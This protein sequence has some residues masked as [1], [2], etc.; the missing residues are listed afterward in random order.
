M[1]V[2]VDMD[3]VLA[4]FDDGH[5]RLCAARGLPTTTPGVGR[6]SWDILG[7]V[8]PAY[9]DVVLE[10]WHSPGFFRGLRPIDGAVAGLRGLVAAG[11]DVW[12]CTAPLRHHATCAHEKLAWV[13][14][15]V[16]R[17]FGERVIVAA[18]KTLIHGDVLIDD[19]PDL[20]GVRA[21]AWEHVLYDASYN[22]AVHDRRRLTW[23]T[24]REVLG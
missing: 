6:T 2:L 20:V 24:W 8:D 1:I 13:A 12:I 19:R 22:R 3:G 18:D 23:A 10:L 4:D 17:D 16:G 11:H 15:H 7:V 21:P 9:R 14:H 5:A